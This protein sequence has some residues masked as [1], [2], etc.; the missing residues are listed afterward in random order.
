MFNIILRDYKKNY[1]F[2]GCTNL[3][4]T[5]IP[6]N[7]TTIE[8]DAFFRCSN[9]TTVN[10]MGTIEQWNQINID[11]LMNDFFFHLFFPFVFG[12]HFKHQS[13]LK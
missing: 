6:A 5:G 3:V 1:A 10:Y 2:D 8:F 7:V 4:N 11:N 9:L 12:A 13:R